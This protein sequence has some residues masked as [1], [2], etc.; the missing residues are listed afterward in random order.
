MS[1]IW[2]LLLLSTGVI[3]FSAVSSFPGTLSREGH[4]LLPMMKGLFLPPSL[5]PP[6]FSLLFFL[7]SSSSLLSLE[8]SSYDRFPRPLPS[9]PPPVPER[10]MRQCR[11]PLSLSSS[12]SPSLPTIGHDLNFSTT[13]F[14]ISPNTIFNACSRE[15]PAPFP[16]HMTSWPLRRPRMV[17]NKSGGTL[18]AKDRATATTWEQ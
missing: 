12:S 10:R 3:V 11:S 16:F 7:R 2:S 4:G 8:L 5:K 18:G 1:S 9:Y 14:S 15:N 13:L 17:A 6:V